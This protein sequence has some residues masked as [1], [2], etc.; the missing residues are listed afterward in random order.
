[1]QNSLFTIHY[2]ELPCPA[3]SWVSLVF[4]AAVSDRRS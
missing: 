2:S 4:V 3:R 1:M